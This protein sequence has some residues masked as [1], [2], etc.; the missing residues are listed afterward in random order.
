KGAAILALV[1][2]FLVNAG[3]ASKVN[4]ETSRGSYLLPPL[5]RFAEG[6]IRIGK[7]QV[8]TRLNWGEAIPTRRL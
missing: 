8:L 1:I 6:I 7:Q 5:S 2:F 4:P 3:S